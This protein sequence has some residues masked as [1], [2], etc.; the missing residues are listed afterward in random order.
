MCNR[1]KFQVRP[2]LEKQH[3]ISQSK[4]TTSGMASNWGTILP[5]KLIEIVFPLPLLQTTDSRPSNDIL[6]SSWCPRWYGFCGLLQV[7]VFSGGRPQPQN[8]GVTMSCHFMTQ[9]SWQAT[10]TL[11]PACQT[12]KECCF[13]EHFWAWLCWSM[14]F[15]TRS[16]SPVKSKEE[17]IDDS[18]MFNHR[19]IQNTQSV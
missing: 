3:V 7:N 14:L 9:L 6:S 15:N 12:E 11:A 17:P 13:L 4:R 2:V 16:K 10:H 19:P 1:N 8:N 5:T 18:R